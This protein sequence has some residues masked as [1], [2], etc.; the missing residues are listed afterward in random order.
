MTFLL[1]VVV[2]LFL[3]APLGFGLCSLVTA[4]KRSD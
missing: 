3:G 4:N 2:G 1:G